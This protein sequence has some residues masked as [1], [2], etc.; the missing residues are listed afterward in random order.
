MNT[1]VSL[2]RRIAI[3]VLGVAFVAALV[4]ALTLSGAAA[5][6][7]S[8]RYDVTSTVRSI[9]DG[10]TE[11][12]Y[13]TNTQTNDD[14]VVTYSIDIDL[15]K[16]TLIAGYKD[17]DSARGSWGM[18][19]VR[20]QAAAAETV[21]GQKVVVAVNA[22][23]YNM[24]TGEPTG[25][26][27]MNGN[28]KKST[29]GNYF[30][31]LKDG[32]AVIRSGALQGDEQEVVGGSTIMIEDGRITAMSGDYD[33]TKYPRTAVGI[34]ADGNV[35]I[36]VA[37][38]RQAPYSSGYSLY[39]L[40]NKMLEVDCV[41]AINL[42]GGGSTTYLAKYAGTD[43]LTLANSPSDG[44]ERSVSSSLLVV[45]EAEA[46]GVFGS[47]VITPDNEVY[48]PGSVVELS[49]IGADTAGYGID[50]PEGAYWQISSESAVSG[51]ITDMPS[52][53]EGEMVARFAAEE[54]ATGTAV[55]E[56]VYDGEVVGS[57]QI[58]LQWPDTLTMLNT[59][60]SLDFSEETDFGLTA[61][62]QTRVV[63]LK[64]GDLVW[65]VGSTGQVDEDGTPIVIGTMNGDVFVADAE[66]TNVTATVTATLSYNNLV[67]VSA[68]VSVGQLPTVAWDF[69]DITDPE[70]GEVITYAED[71]YTVAYDDSAFFQLSTDGNGSGT[72]GSAQ[73][74]DTST[75]EVRAGQ[76]AL[77]INYDF[78]QNA[79]VQTTA[80]L[81]LG[82]SSRY[83]VPGHPTGLGV[84]IY[85]PEGTPNFWLRSY[86]FGIDENGEPT[87]GNV[88]WGG[89]KGAYVL[90]FNSV[91]NVIESGWKYYE[92]DLTGFTNIPYTWILTG[93]TFRIMQLS[94]FGSPV[95]GYLYLDNFQ[96]VY[97]ANT[98]DLYAPEINSVNINS[99][100][101]V[102]L[103]E[104]EV[105]DIS[106]DPFYVYA[107][108]EEFTGL[109]EE[110]LAEIE[111]ENER[112][113]LEKA[114][115]YATGVNDENIHVYIDGNE[116]ELENVNETYLL[117][118][119][120]SLPN[121]RHEIT[122]EVYDNFQNLATKSYIVNVGNDSNYSEVSLQGS[123]DTPYLGANYLL[124]LVADI[125]ES[126]QEVTFEIR[127]ASG[128]E[129]K[130]GESVPGFTV[131]Q[132][133]LTHVNNNIYTVTVTRDDSV[134]YSGDGVIASFAIP[135]STS[136]QE[137]SVL[138]YSIESALV[139]Y[140]N[141][142]QENVIN[143]FYAED[144]LE[145]VSYYTI[146]ADTMIVGS[147]GGYIYVYGP[148][149]VTPAAGVTVTVD[150]EE[151]GETDGDGKIF[152]DAFVGAAGYKT[153]AAH[154]DEGYSYGQRVYG[155]V[156]GGA[157]DESNQPSAEP[158][159]VRAVATTNGN[160]E[161]R[162]VWLS[163]PLAAENVAVVRYATLADYQA[164]GEAAF[165][166]L[167]GTCQLLEF[168]GTYAV[169]VN[170]VLLQN[171]DEGTEYVYQVGDGTVW[172]T[173]KYFATAKYSATTDFIVIGDTQADNPD[174]FNSYGN[175]IT[176]S[177][178]DY[179]FAIQTGDFVDN[180]GNYTQWGAILSIFSE[181]FSDIDFVH[182][183]GNHEYS[184]SVDGMYPAVMN[185]TPSADYY[186]VTYGNVYI[187][188]INCYNVED[189]TEAIEWIKQ[190]A[191]ESDAVW[192][193]L[194][195][196]RPPYY[197]N[198]IGGSEN[199]HELIP[200]LVDEAG[201][202][203]VFSG[204]DHSYARTQPMTGGEV[205]KENGA[206]YYIV[207]A[208]EKGGKYAITDNP[209]F[210][211]AKTSGDFNALYFSVSATYTQMIIT[212]YNLTDDGSFEVFDEYTINNDC[213]PDNH[214][215]YYET[216]S[217]M[218]VCGHCHYE[219]SP[220][221][222]SFSG[223]IQDEEGRNIFFTAG[224]KQTGWITIG[225][226]EYYFDENGVAGQGEMTVTT[227]YGDKFT[228]VFDNGIVSG[229]DTGWN[230]SKT[231]FYEDGVMAQGWRQIDGTIYYFLTGNE[232]TDLNMMG[233]TASGAVLIKTPTQPY[234]TN[235]M[236]YFNS[237][238]SVAHG[239][240]HQTGENTW[241]Y[242]RVRK[243]SDH[244]GIWVAYCYN[245]WVETEYGTFY[246]QMNSVLATGELV[247]D[248]V[249]YR[250]S[251]SGSTPYEGFGT[252]LGRYYSVEFVADGN[253]I[254]KEQIFE[255]ETIVAPAAPEKQGNSIKSYEFVGWYNGE[256]K[257]EEGV[258]VSDDVVYTAKYE[259]VYTETYTTVSGL[260]DALSAASTPAEKHEALDALSE[261]YETLSDVQLTDME[262][263]GLS[264]ALYEEM[265][266]NL[267]TV[268]F[269]YEGQTF[270]QKVFYDGEAIVAPSAPEKQ[271]NS[272]KSYVF[273]GWYNGDILLEESTV[274]TSDA[275]SY[276]ARFSTAYTQDYIAM[277]AALEALEDVSGGTLE[278]KYA[279][280]TAVY[281][282][283][284]TFSEQHRTDAEAEGL[285]FA[286]YESM[287]S[288][289][290]AVVGG[291][292]EDVETAVNVAD[293]IMNAAAALSLFAAAAYVASKE[294]IL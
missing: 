60:F 113:R 130:A 178:I 138:S 115:V 227:Q 199:S 107:S 188:V 203:V 28:V 14:Q 6:A 208:A 51:E 167:N 75:G 74:V 118:S 135:C 42:D 256:Q 218:L 126:V 173:D 18:Q 79:T 272:I 168:T 184:G 257:Y 226:D 213:Y 232:T 108:Y 44:Q 57:A 143:S 37:D 153:V 165:V 134:T 217:G 21:R 87:A 276:E 46:T 191:A 62:W 262:A 4:L 282:L 233:H 16:N 19:S 205:D 15:S 163:N 273:D 260:L 214:E 26:L 71:I 160:T 290:N 141:G 147:D 157:V 69:E 111:D 123:G 30:A 249:T 212:V 56:L 246:A 91:D 24:G 268:T 234:M 64:S 283:M 247:I 25:S 88:G 270:A 166:T 48:T 45:S 5:R 10:V 175:A 127:L 204:H 27:V 255:G 100:S 40:A 158:L 7:D 102:A 258:T 112:D 122:V 202:D 292:A 198:E 150:G 284:K 33:T 281:D 289:Y 95:S 116:V 83:E 225:E 73:I 161:Q 114:S 278:Q 267:I 38:G 65:T 152:T 47:A 148:D 53:A 151:I 54:G 223:L 206:V 121:G 181:Y 82:P 136:L 231:R 243:P 187:A 109:S 86:I 117:T 90:N 171:L 179:D 211:F 35:V 263:E 31:I 105:T 210:H 140:E 286:L 242:T 186:A 221:E 67:T 78:T 230:D 124:D 200:A 50:I 146:D 176:N 94:G 98:D 271:G 39:D 228:F 277:E 104:D 137:G 9:S 154:S 162:I 177:G 77:Q 266:K 235:Y 129:I 261:V 76:H 294:V 239:D 72:T 279:A 288:E 264:F 269:T 20:E 155:V 96:F 41:S 194:T 180:G 34:K 149:G 43:E 172:S 207:G 220:E 164:N 70:T 237:D 192:K 245:Q 209:D 2:L 55:V 68:E 92:A 52:E 36:M 195:L 201:F 80:G 132:C 174:V 285:S 197:T 253:Q 252:L 23:F 110:E 93:Q 170:H 248:G 159:Y 251:E 250:F 49:A 89:D 58:K 240:F 133:E 22:D 216:S 156:A 99:E 145:V 196:H 101:G 29:A 189:M 32:T 219:V 8:G 125:P 190:D 291:A 215:Y 3:S 61:Y 85:A 1:K 84:W 81:Y 238:G 287:L 119:A 103:S 139:T 254:S 106:D 244:D 144:S 120:I 17:Y 185:F 169:Y 182:V 293:R 13:Y 229:G 128:F 275:T 59:V 280:L 274:A 259:V 142:V 183:F 12:Q 241:V 224:A 222:I 131:T 11:T 193:V 265:L 63:H 66:A 236:F 97:G